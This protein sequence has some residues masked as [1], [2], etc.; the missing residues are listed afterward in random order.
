[1]TR[2]MLVVGIAV[3]LGAPGMA[4]RAQEPRPVEIIDKAIRAH[5]GEEKLTGLSTFTFRERQVY[6][7]DVT[8]DT[9]T[10]VQLPGR[11]RRDMKINSE[12]KSRSSLMVFD[13]DQGWMSRWYPAGG[14]P[15]RARD[16]PC[17]KPASWVA[18]KKAQARSAFL[19]RALIAA[20]VLAGRPK[21]TWIAVSSLS[22]KI[23]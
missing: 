11:Y 16:S 4:A 23:L 9:Q 10:V 14:A 20:G 12:G 17:S 7:E 5:G 18:S 1:M 21:R 6:P 13:G 15:N 22:S 2:S 3:V 8:W 19:I